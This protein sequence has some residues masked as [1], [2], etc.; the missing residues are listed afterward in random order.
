MMVPMPKKPVD[1]GSMII[2]AARPVVCPSCGSDDPAARDLDA[3]LAPC[4][5]GW[6]R[7][8][9][10]SPEPDHTPETETSPT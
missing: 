7:G 1:D 2:Q 5:S 6:H 3:W 9:S 10:A 4:T 8:T